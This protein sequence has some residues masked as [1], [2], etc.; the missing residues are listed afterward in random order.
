[1]EERHPSPEIHSELAEQEG[2]ADVKVFILIFE[3]FCIP[4]NIVID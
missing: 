1:M 2:S 3:N 4:R